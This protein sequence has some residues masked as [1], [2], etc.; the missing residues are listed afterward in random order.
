[1]IF[2]S[3]QPSQGSSNKRQGG[4]GFG[5]DRVWQGF[6]LLREFPLNFGQDCL[7][8]LWTLAGPAPLRA[9]SHC[10][11]QLAGYFTARGKRR[12]EVSRG[13][14]VKIKLIRS[15]KAQNQG[16]CTPPCTL[17]PGHFFAP[18]LQS[19]CPPVSSSCCIPFFSES[20]RR[21]ARVLICCLRQQPQLAARMGR[22]SAY[23]TDSDR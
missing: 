16:L 17:H 3:E 4:A 21:K 2:G 11:T 13:A 22:P 12:G 9:R 7:G 19:P 1:M 6:P 15:S 20:R 10:A 8:K 23:E 18:C 14:E 5:G